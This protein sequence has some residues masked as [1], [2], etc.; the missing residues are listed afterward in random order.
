MPAIILIAALQSGHLRP[1]CFLGS[2][3]KESYRRAYLLYYLFLL[4]SLHICR[5]G[6]L[7]QVWSLC[8]PLEK[9]V[10]IHSNLW[11]IFQVWQKDSNQYQQQNFEEISH[12][13]KLQVVPFGRYCLQIWIVPAKPYQYFCILGKQTIGRSKS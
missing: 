5:K 2:K 10:K 9:H 8:W 7:F 4:Y 3:R 6:L 11:S 1:P 12:I 13:T